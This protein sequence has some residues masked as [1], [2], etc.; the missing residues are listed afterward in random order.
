MAQSM[1][2]CPK[3]E[4][5][6]PCDL[7]QGDGMVTLLEMNEYLDGLADNDAMRDKP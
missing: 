2:P 4:Q 6:G 7:C 1:Y 5:R 3:C